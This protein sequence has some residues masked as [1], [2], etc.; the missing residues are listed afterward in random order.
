[1]I[2]TPS[3]SCHP[4]FPVDREEYNPS[5]TCLIIILSHINIILLLGE[6]SLLCPFKT[7]H[8]YTSVQLHKTNLRREK[9]KYISE[10]QEK[11]ESRNW[12][13]EQNVA[14]QLF[15]PNHFQSSV[16]IFFI[17]E[18]TACNVSCVCLVWVSALADF[19]EAFSGLFK[20]VNH[21]F[22]GF[23]L[24]LIIIIFGFG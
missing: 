17:L 24:L 20:V 5:G 7:Q 22:L 9:K 19:W 16:L 13:P 2:V 6:V 11:I 3:P 15:L 21:F 18:R 8:L 1:M 10:M 4:S 23:I 14:D 12:N